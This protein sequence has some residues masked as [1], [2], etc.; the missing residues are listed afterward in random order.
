[1]R[2][3]EPVVG[4]FLQQVEHLRGL[5]GVHPV[6]ARALLEFRAFGVH[7]LLDLF[8]HGAAQQIR[9]AQRVIRHDLGDL[10]NLFLIDDDAL[11]FLKDMINQ[12]VH[13]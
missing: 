4:E 11:G 5:L 6:L 1:M 12:R 2:F 8:A 13:G 10:H 3:V 7:R 9:A